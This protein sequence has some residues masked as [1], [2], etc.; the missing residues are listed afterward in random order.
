ML[1]TFRDNGDLQCSLTSVPNG[2]S[3]VY[4]WTFEDDRSL[5]ATLSINGN[6]VLASYN[7]GSAGHWDRLGPYPATVSNGT[8]QDRDIGA[9][10]KAIQAFSVE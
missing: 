4:V 1:R 5:N 7:S 2:S 8:I 10:P 9:T 6:V 3:D